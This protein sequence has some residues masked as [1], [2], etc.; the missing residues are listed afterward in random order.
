MT[1]PALLLTL[2]LAADP[3]AAAP[4]D[5]AAPVEYPED[6]YLATGRFVL[7]TD[8]VLDPTARV[9]TRTGSRNMVVKCDSLGGP[10][11]VVPQEKAVRSLDASM[12]L[13]L[14]EDALKVLAGAAGKTNLSTLSIEGAAARFAAAGHQFRLAPAPNVLGRIDMTA[15]L[16]KSPEYRRVAQGYQP[17]AEDVATLRRCD[18][19]VRV[20]VFFGSWC[21]F[22]SRFM[23][24]LIRVLQ[25]GQNPQIEVLFHGVPRNISL[26]PTARAAGIAGVPTAIVSVGGRELGRLE[27]KMWHQPEVALAAMISTL[28]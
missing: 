25:E 15:L 1:V 24:R 9:F 3:S 27:S 28:P 10:V 23:P 4:A 7:E 14:D 8:G 17:S 20:D 13:V 26:D 2:L 6:A 16:A 5:P 12:L 19:P 21:G 18:Q 22:C 11:Y